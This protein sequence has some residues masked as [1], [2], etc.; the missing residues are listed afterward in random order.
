[1]LSDSAKHI[2]KSYSYKAREVKHHEIFINEGFDDSGPTSQLWTLYI[3]YID[4]KN[5]FVIDKY[6]KNYYFDNDENNNYVKLITFIN[7]NT[8]DY[9]KNIPI[10]EKIN[11]IRNKFIET[12]VL[13]LRLQ[14]NIN[15]SIIKDYH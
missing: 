7:A 4:S 1:M 10:S 6:F 12:E 5:N 9:Y 15:A 8:V 14:K 3:E 2:I 13:N 11:N